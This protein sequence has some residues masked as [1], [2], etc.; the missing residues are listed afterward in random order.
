M[1]YEMKRGESLGTLISYAGGFA[2][3]AYTRSVRVRRKTGRQYSIFN[4]NEFDMRSF[5]VADEDSI[6]VDSVIPRYENMV[7]IKGAVFRPGMYEVGGRINSVRGLIE[8]ADG[9]T[10]VAFA[11]HAVLHRRKADRTLEVI[12]VDVD[13][14]LTGRVADI[15]LQNEDVLF[16]P[17]RTDAQE[18][19][20]ITIHGEVLYPG[21]YQYADNESLEDFILQAGGLK[22]T[23]STV[24]VD[25]SRR[26]TNP[27]SNLPLTLSSHAL[28]PSHCVMASSLMVLRVSYLNPTMRSMYARVRVRPTNRM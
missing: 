20:T 24:K 2:G 10:E 16:I 26:I 6:S 15:P 8:A 11:P 27:Q 9:L 21:I 22:Q 25:V 28:T 5:R 12:S 14:I 7:E 4:V 19:R 18:Q 3:D 23:A 17:T 13:G 1:F